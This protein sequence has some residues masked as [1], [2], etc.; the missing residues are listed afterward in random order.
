VLKLKTRCRDGTTHL[1]TS[2]L[3][4][5]RRHIEWQLRGSQ[6][7]KRDVGSGSSAGGRRQG[8]QSLRPAIDAQF[9]SLF[10]RRMKFGFLG[11]AADQLTGT[12]VSFRRPPTL[13]A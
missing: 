7:C 11:E 1:V 12:K 10:M 4:L 13:A 8:E 9:L 6:I 2:P 5:M 3:E